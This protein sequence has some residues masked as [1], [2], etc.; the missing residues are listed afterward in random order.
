MT[1]VTIEISDAQNAVLEAERSEFNKMIALGKGEGEPSEA[2]SSSRFAQLFWD[3]VANAKVAEFKKRERMAVAN[4][5]A[6]ADTK[7]QAD[8]KTLL[9]LA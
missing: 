3:E 5:F 6:S 8:I 4:T 7:T 2:I 1:Q 9:K